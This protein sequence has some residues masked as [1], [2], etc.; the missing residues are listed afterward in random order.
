MCV[1]RDQW[2]AALVGAVTCGVGGPEI[3][4]LLTTFWAVCRRSS[5]HDANSLLVLPLLWPYAFI[6]FGPPA[7]LLGANG[8]MFLQHL[9]QRTQSL[10]LVIAEAIA[11]GSILGSIVP[12]SC[13]VYGWGPTKDAMELS[14]LAAPTGA[15]CSLVVLCLLQR[16]H[17]LRLKPKSTV[18]L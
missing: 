16:W 13:V 5:N 18:I 10:K 1:K 12:L 4:L 15:C 3:G 8:G 7:F 6:P 2:K 9:A 11:G 17:L 14:L